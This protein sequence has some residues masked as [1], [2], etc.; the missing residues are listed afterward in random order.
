VPQN[1]KRVTLAEWRRQ[2]TTRPC[3]E[4][5]VIPLEAHESMSKADTYGLR[6]SEQLPR[7][8]AVNLR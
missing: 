8:V 1:L 4:C 5:L 7:L 6:Q 3:V 2:L